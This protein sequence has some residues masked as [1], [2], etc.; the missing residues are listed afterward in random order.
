MYDKLFGTSGIRGGIVDKVTPELALKL[1]L[2]A[3]KYL[4]FDG[5]IAIGFDNRTSNVMLEKAFVS[6]VIAGGCDAELLG[7][8]P[9]PVLAYGTK[10]LKSK[11]GIM[12]TASHN[13][14]SDNGFK[15]FD[16]QGKEYLPAEENAIECI[17]KARISQFSNKTG[18]IKSIP[19]ISQQYVE[20]VLRKTSRIARQIK[21]ILDCANGTASNVVP[22][23]LSTAG[24]RTIALNDNVDGTF[25]G[26][27]SEPSPQNLSH[28]MEVV[29]SSSADIGL[30]YDSDADRVAVIDEKGSFV[31]NDRIIALIAKQK[32][33]EDGPGTIVTSLD[34]SN[35][36]DDVIIPLKG[37][38]MRVRLGKTHTH[39]DDSN[40]I[41]AAEPWKIIDPSWGMWADGIFTSIRIVEMLN[42]NGASVSDLLKYVPSYPQTHLNFPCPELFKRKAI[43]MIMTRLSHER[44]VR[45]MWK[46]DGVRVNYNDGS[47][48]LFRV[49][50]TEPKIRLYCEAKEIYKMNELVK[51]GKHLITDSINHVMKA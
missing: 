36:I 1:G 7:I 17:M 20:A 22:F 5:T 15:L 46:I 10:I 44:D 47:W 25:P 24:C 49:S 14:S 29:K 42:D 18:L 40:V 38:I 27:P 26:R 32:L 12:I 4:N 34:T 11:T 51:K 43:G 28:I 3:A 21:V 48:M 8:V 16:S 23:I 30:A 33:E 39:L 41:L 13:P 31:A 9:L 6:G 2:S 19:S 50:G 35:C 45:D 37:K